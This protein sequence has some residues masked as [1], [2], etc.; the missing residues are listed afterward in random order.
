[1][2]VTGG[3]D[4]VRVIVEAGQVEVLLLAPG[5]PFRVI[6]AKVTEVDVAVMV[7]VEE[8]LLETTGTGTT[9]AVTG[10]TGVDTEVE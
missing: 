6:V 7:V 5:G 9:V 3:S 2:T 4:T 1:M 8:L 10:A